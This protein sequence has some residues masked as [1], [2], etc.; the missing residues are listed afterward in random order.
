[1]RFTNAAADAKATGA[2]YTAALLALLGDRDPMGVQQQLVDAVSA[3]VAGLSKEVLQTPERAG[4]WSIIQVLQH[5]VE[6]ELVYAYRVRT[7]L[8]RHTPAIEGYDQDRWAAVLRYTDAT[9]EESLTELRALRGRNLRLY[10]A[11]S[12]EELDRYGLHEE[13]GQESVRHIRALIAAHDLLHRNQI[14]RIKRALI[15]GERAT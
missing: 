4:K 6:T 12:D 8:A 14:D 5:L 11:L 7:I 1:M 10:R 2:E 15:G 3:S 9:V 13:R